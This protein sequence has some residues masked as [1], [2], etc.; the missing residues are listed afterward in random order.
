MVAPGLVEK[1]RMVIR[2]SLKDGLRVWVERRAVLMRSRK[3][4]TEEKEGR[5]GVKGLVRRFTKKMLEEENKAGSDV[6][7]LTRQKKKAQ[8]TWAR[9]V[10][11]ARKWE[12]TRTTI[13]VDSEGGGRCN[14]PTRAHV[15][16]LR[17]FWE[18]LSKAAAG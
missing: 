17:T 7:R 9:D 2:E 16:G 4:E 6:V 14:Q 15:L 18:G 10:E 13:S 11:A 1:R 12:D 8:A 5:I 3:Y